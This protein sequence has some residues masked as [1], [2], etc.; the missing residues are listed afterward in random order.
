MDGRG[1]EGGVRYGTRIEGDQVYVQT[2]DGPLV[3]GSVATAIDAVGGPAWTIDYS[4][5]ERQRYPELDTA[6]E[7]LVVDVRDMLAAME[8]DADF[9]ESLRALPASPRDGDDL[10]PRMGLFV[11]KLL[12]NLQSGVA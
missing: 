8:H 9:V 11:G 1:Q 6:D 3:V 4:D 10:S 7:G 5:W 12:E 2:E